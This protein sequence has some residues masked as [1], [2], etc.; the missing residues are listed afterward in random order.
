MLSLEDCRSIIRPQPATHKSNHSKVYVSISEPHTPAMD[1]TDTHPPAI[2]SSTSHQWTPTASSLEKDEKQGDGAL[3]QERMRTPH[4]DGIGANRSNLVQHLGY[5][6]D[7]SSRYYEYGPCY[8]QGVVPSAYAIVPPISVGS[9]DWKY[10]DATTFI[11]PPPTTPTTSI[12]PTTPA[13]RAATSALL[14]SPMSV[15]DTAC[16]SSDSA[17]IA[18][19]DSS[20]TSSS[21]KRRKRVKPEFKIVHNYHDNADMTFR[22]FMDSHPGHKPAR[23]FKDHISFPRALHAMLDFVSKSGQ[24]GIVSWSSHGRAFSIQK[25]E[26]FTKFLI[27]K[28]YQM[29]NYASFLRQLNIYG[30]KCISRDGPDKGAYYHVS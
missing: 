16:T 22:T 6:A 26:E 8:Y 17:A 13:K 5:A 2:P 18:I 27:P 23:E 24:T 10:G 7:P 30:F 3:Y 20:T 28:Y 11:P 4:S 25:P 14:M 1:R 29:K 21:A 12:N 9:Q 19:K 15:S